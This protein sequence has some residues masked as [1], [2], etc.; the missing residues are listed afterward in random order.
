[1]SHPEKMFPLPRRVMQ[2]WK[3]NIIPTEWAVSP[4]SIRNFLPNWEYT[5]MTDKMN[6]AFITEHF[7]WFEDT[8]N[9]FPY[10]IQRA[11]A[12]RYA[13]L[14]IN[15]GLYLDLDFE[16]VAPLEE[17][18]WTLKWGNKPSHHLFLLRSANTANITNAFMA[19]TPGH[20]LWLEVMKEMMQPPGISS[21]EKHWQVM[22][23]TG[24]HMLTRVLN[25]TEFNYQLLP[26]SR[27][28]P[29]TMCNISEANGPLG[30]EALARQLPGSSWV[31]GWGKVWQW[32]YCNSRILIVLGIVIG[33]LLILLAL[34]W[35][36]L[37]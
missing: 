22:E 31:T 7:P 14:Y 13:W 18:F 30:P 26:S 15:G 21:L 10:P 23:T 32:C 8:Y 33:L 28:N 27:L 4:P 16:L 9:N 2:T 5:L 25:R 36:K 3:T 20:P 1:M 17:I 24:P 35:F 37:Y 12:I 11:D 34:V 19:S 29:C 6:L